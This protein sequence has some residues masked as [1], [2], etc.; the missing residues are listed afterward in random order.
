MKKRK[1][2]KEVWFLWYHRKL[3]SFFELSRNT[4]NDVVIMKAR[5]E[6][7]DLTSDLVLIGIIEVVR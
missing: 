1:R 2:I 3:D 4:T 6:I 7:L 5:H